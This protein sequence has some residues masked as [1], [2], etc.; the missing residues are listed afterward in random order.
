VFIGSLCLNCYVKLNKL[1][2][3]PQRLVF[4]YCRFCGAIRVGYRW[5]EGGELEEAVVRYAETV[6]ASVKPCSDYVTSY[7]LA[8]IEPLTEVSWRTMVRAHYSI[9]LSGEVWVEQAYD[10]EVRA[11]PSICPSCHMARGGDYNVVVQLRG[12]L[13]SELVR[14]IA[15]KLDELGGKVIDVVERDKG[16]DVLLEDRSAASR[17]LKELR[18]YARLRIKYSG[19]DVGVGSTGRLRRRLVISVRVEG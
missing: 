15:K 6:L 1:L 3:V 4:D 10:V 2:C 12:K 13:S 17:L 8:R 11:N 14:R 16:I 19:E 7:K 9:Q 18:K 5:L